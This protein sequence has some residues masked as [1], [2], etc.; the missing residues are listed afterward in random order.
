MNRNSISR[1][2]R[3]EF[4]RDSVA[5]YLRDILLLVNQFHSIED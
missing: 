1:N 5:N 2:I 3:Y 4:I